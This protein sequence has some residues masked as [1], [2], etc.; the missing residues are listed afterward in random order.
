MSDINI[1]P[2]EKFWSVNQDGKVSLNNYKFKRFLEMNHFFKNRPNPNS[3]F[4]IIKKNG[5]FLEIVDE[6]EVKDFVL[7]HILKERLSEDVYNLMTSNIKFFK[8]DY[9][10]M[11][12]SKEIKVL[13]DTKD[14]AYLFYENGVLEVTKDKSEL[15]DYKDFN[16]NIWENQVIKR[17]Y[18]SSDHHDSEFRK[19]VWKISGGIDINDNSSVEDKNKYDT[20]VDRYNSFQTAIGY[21]I[22][23]YKTSGNNKA[24]ILNDEMISDSPN[25]RSGKGVFWNSLKHMK[26]LQSIDGKQF[27]FGGDFP[28][29]S[30]KTDCQILVFDDVKKN[31]QFEN[32]FSVITEG[33]DI[34][35]KGKDTIKLPVEDSPKI[36]ISTNYVLKGNGDSHDAR[37][38]ELEL[39]TFFNANNTPYEFFGHYLFTD[40]DKL[41][42]AR[43]DCYMIECLKKYLN[44]GLVSY[45]SISLPLK[46][47]EANLGK[48]LFEFCLELPKN[49][50][51]SG[52]ETYDKYKF[53]ISKSF[54]AKSKKEV[55]QSIKKFCDFFGYEYE[56]RTPG[57]LLKFMITE[58][59][60]TPKEVT[61][62]DLDI[63]D[64]I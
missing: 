16:L 35:Y 1:N 19:F 24:I 58:R 15:K 30:V 36:V 52:Q 62:S 4:N 20:A 54:M 6:V 18:V 47:L 50:W 10:S 11:I 33:I 7:N 3:T 5:I 34:T 37:K 27:K 17:K 31:F 21:L 29:Q 26:K 57:G 40:W 49:E 25:G 2:E 59:S 63:W 32:L 22:H 8:R 55:T 9:L 23:S 44:N 43:F 60:I 38:F 28:Y 64:T 41:E 56:T 45:K 53:S 14:I 12:E 48:E 42:W 13:K 51:L 39:S 61:E 46:K